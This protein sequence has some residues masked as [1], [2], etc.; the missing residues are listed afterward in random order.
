MWDER[1]SGRWMV[2]C[3]DQETLGWMRRVM[4]RELTIM[5][6]ESSCKG[7]VSG[8]SCLVEFLRRWCRYSKNWKFWYLE[9]CTNEDTVMVYGI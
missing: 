6:I 9:I 2:E 1:I 8:S 3:K 5:V 4:A 7:M